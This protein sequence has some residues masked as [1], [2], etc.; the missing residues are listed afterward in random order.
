MKAHTYN[1]RNA[2]AA[3]KLAEDRLREANLRLALGYLRD[4]CGRSEFAQ[5]RA[6]KEAA[7]KNVQACR[8]EIEALRARKIAEALVREIIKKGR[9]NVWGLLS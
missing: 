3:I 8:A 6:A 5:L 1:K 9:Q 2:E 7:L 4:D